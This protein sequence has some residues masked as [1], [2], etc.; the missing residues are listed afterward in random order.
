MSDIARSLDFVRT[1]VAGACISCGR[2]V[3]SVELIAVSK[4]F[5]V[6][7]I[8]SAIDCGQ[9]HFGESRLQEA[10]P[11]IKELPTHLQ[12][13]FIGRV[14]SN[15][16]RKILPL[17]GVI[18]S[19]DSVK[20]AAYINN[21]A[22]EISLS[23]EAFLQVNIGGELSK[24]GV[25]TGEVEGA[26]EAILR[27][28]HLQL[29]GLMCVPPPVSDPE[30]AR[31]WFASLREMRDSLE[32]KFGIRLPSLSMGMS[33]DFTVAIEEGSTH[34]RVGSAIFGNRPYRV[35]GELG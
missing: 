19:V 28:D 32:G 10:E 13:H 1:A 30:M 16:V 9:I 31:G 8:T 22:N 34:V 18:H 7:D 27:F 15:K 6:K 20:L 17:F 11:K 12:W 35:E 3:D 23:P 25:E 33:H 4:T 26:M 5:G 29:R 24:G 14:Q 2:K 21:V